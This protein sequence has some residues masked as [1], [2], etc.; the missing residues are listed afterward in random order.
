MAR[1]KNKKKSKSS[2]RR[3]RVRGAADQ[4]AMM[5]ILGGII[6]GIGLTVANQKVAF[7]QGKIIGL[8]ETGLGSLMTWKIASPFAKG[9]GIGIAIAGSTN[10]AKGFGLLAGVG[11][12]R[13]F[14]QMQPALNGF[15]QVPKIGSPNLPGRQFPQ[16]GSVGKT[17][18]RMYAG[19]YGGN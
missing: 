12:P 7:L 9:L 19:V 13:N 11:A 2:G 8:V 6:G 3:G 10:A 4:D 1:K 16:P 5:M 15:R 18:P 14:R 17:S